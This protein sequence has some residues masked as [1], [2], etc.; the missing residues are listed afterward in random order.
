MLRRK[1][2]SAPPG[3]LVENKTDEPLD[4]PAEAAVKEA[5]TKE[6]TK[7]EAWYNAIPPDDPIKPPADFATASPEISAI[8]N[9]KTV[10][11]DGFQPTVVPTNSKTGPKFRSLPVDIPPPMPRI[12]PYSP[13]RVNKDPNNPNWKSSRLN[14]HA[15]YPC[16]QLK[17][18]P[19][20]NKC[21]CTVC[22]KCKYETLLPGVCSMC[23]LN[24]V[25]RAMFCRN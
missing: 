2:F 9:R 12:R 4:T 11:P 21:P 25:E 19:Y 10:N 6:V 24:C 3:M 1:C 7:I 5:R 18:D 23:D 14:P 15:G 20:D 22:K 16:R 8:R 13:P 17:V